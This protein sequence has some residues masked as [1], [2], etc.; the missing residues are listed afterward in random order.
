VAVA[1]WL[2]ACFIAG[3]FM[4]G[5]GAGLVIISMKGANSP[6]AVVLMASFS[7]VAPA[8][9]LGAN[10]TMLRRGETE[11]LAG[12]SWSVGASTGRA[13][14]LRRGCSA[15]LDWVPAACIVG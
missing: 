4:S 11:P 5:G 13:T 15:S 1:G 14:P 12:R 7:A 9:W 2:L 3:V 8:A 6:E 10:A